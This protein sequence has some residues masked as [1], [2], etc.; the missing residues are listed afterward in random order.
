[1][2]CSMA[3]KWERLG[4]LSSR[5]GPGELAP[6]PR[7]LDVRGSGVWP[8]KGGPVLPPLV[9]VSH[10]LLS[11]F[12][13]EQSPVPRQVGP[14]GAWEEETRTFSLRAGFRFVS[15]V[16]PTPLSRSSSSW[17]AG[18]G[19]DFRCPL[20]T[21]PRGD[22]ARPQGGLTLRSPAQ[23]LLKVEEGSVTA[24]LAHTGT[25]QDRRAQSRTCGRPARGGLRGAG[26]EAAC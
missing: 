7:L 17:E 23:A 10:R 26:T 9:P 12:S 6:E 18:S 16:A 3:R 25:K 1:M 14:R 13:R 5:E 24:V 21:Q 11:D 19:Q 20:Q 22:G 4:H 8:A 15:S 2:T